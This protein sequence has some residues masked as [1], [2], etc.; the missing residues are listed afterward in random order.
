MRSLSRPPP[1]RPSGPG[2]L[3]GFRDFSARVG[4][5]SSPLRLFNLGLLIAA[6][7]FARF[8]ALVRGGVLRAGELDSLVESYE[9]ARRKAGKA[10]AKAWP[11]AVETRIAPILGR[12]GK[13]KDPAALGMLRGEYGGRDP[14]LIAAAGLAMLGSGSEAG[15]HATIQGFNRGGGWSTYA[16]VRVL[17]GLAATRRPAALDFLL[18][19]ARGGSEEIQVL[20]IRSL[21]GYPGDAKVAEAVLDGLRSR[22]AL[23]RAAALESLKRF[24]IKKMVPAL[25]ER[26]RRER[27]ETMRADALRLLVSRTGHNMGL[28]AGDWDKW[29]KETGDRFEFPEAGSTGASRASTVVV[30]TY[31]GLEVASRRVA[32]LVDASL[33]MLQPVKGPKKKTKGKKRNL[34]GAPG[35]KMAALKKELTRLLEELPD[36]AAVNIIFFN[37]GPIPWKTS[38]HP[39]RGRGRQQAI[40]FVQGL[41]CKL[42]TNIYDSLALALEDRRVDTIFLLSDGKPTAGSGP[43]SRPADIL[44]EIG[45]RNRVRGARIHCISFGKETAFLERL[46][47]Q[48]GGVHR[49]TGG[50]GGRGARKGKK[51][52]KP[53]N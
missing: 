32:F 6:V 24:K 47:K 36:E 18:G 52:R 22:R 3:R 17:D 50:G 37:R 39:L 19:K 27:D 28:A 5:L 40:S 2:N 15:L 48:N 1:G 33:S 8:P 38:L 13:L 34:K 35:T 23:V 4:T 49:S 9:Q 14:Y 30:P 20:A 29:W 31:F 43:F 46:A 45:A 21:A 42:K 41:E 12:I 10:G 51:A 53:A 11:R 25:I 7:L 44:R 26:V 16:R